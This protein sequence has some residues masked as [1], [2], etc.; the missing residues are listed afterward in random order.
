MDPP[1]GGRPLSMVG[2][3][4]EAA[5]NAA[6]ALPAETSPPPRGLRPGIG[7]SSTARQ[8]R[9][10]KHGEQNTTTR[11]TSNCP[12]RLRESIFSAAA[13]RLT[14]C[15]APTSRTGLTRLRFAVRSVS[16]RRRGDSSPRI[17]ADLPEKLAITTSLSPA[18]SDASARLRTTWDLRH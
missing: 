3:F 15:R 2:P 9:S 10:K 5:E 13:P 7:S 18:S 16:M 11:P 4:R 6:F 12:C 17:D 1:S 8:G 14:F